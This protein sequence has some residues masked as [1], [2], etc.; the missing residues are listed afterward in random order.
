MQAPLSYIF[1]NK[2]LAL[3]G[4]WVTLLAQVLPKIGLF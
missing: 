3:R 4:V 2:F 1:K